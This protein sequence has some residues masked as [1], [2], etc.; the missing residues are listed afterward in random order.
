MIW[1]VYQTS[2]QSKTCKKGILVPGCPLD[3]KFMN[4]SSENI[5]LWYNHDHNKHASDAL[6]KSAMLV[7]RLV[8]NSF[9]FVS[10]L[11]L[12]GILYWLSLVHT[13]HIMVVSN[14]IEAFNYLWWVFRIHH[15]TP[16]THTLMKRKLLCIVFSVCQY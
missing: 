10:S 5:L 16:P 8:S 7:H 6:I 15:N 9:S 14:S 12:V 13:F 3:S 2:L 11:G 1:N 4:V